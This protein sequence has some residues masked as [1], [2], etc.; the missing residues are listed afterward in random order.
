MNK[1]FALLLALCLATTASYAGGERGLVRALVKR[2]IT[3]QTIKNSNA[4]YFALA[5]NQLQAAPRAASYLGTG[6]VEMGSAHFSPSYRKPLFADLNPFGDR[7]IQKERFVQYSNMYFPLSV[8]A[9]SAWRYVLNKE[10]PTL[11][12][13]QQPANSASTSDMEWLASQVPAHTSYFLVGVSHPYAPLQNE[14]AQLLHQ[15]RQQQPNRKIFLVTD[16][17]PLDNE[18]ESWLYTAVDGLPNSIQQAARENNI[19]VLG[20]Q[21]S[22]VSL[23]MENYPFKRISEDGSTV[24]TDFQPLFQTTY[25]QEWLAASYLETLQ[26]LK[27]KHPDALFVVHTTADQALYSYPVS[28]G[29]LLKKKEGVFSAVFYPQLPTMPKLFDKKLVSMFDA[30]TNGLFYDS[31]L[32]QFQGKKEVTGFDVQVKVPGQYQQP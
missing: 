17:W 18:W 25:G 29:N 4:F 6:P 23:N 13:F 24:Y 12:H 7:Y 15:L 2:H 9:I 32:L 16:R 28:L 22:V 27:Q 20:M 26:E 30:E 8:A 3:A 11:G 10:L 14:V 21:P 1:N 31:R 5:Q 19:Q